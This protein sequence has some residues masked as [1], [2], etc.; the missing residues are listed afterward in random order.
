MIALGTMMNP[1][2]VMAK[3]M[4]RWRGI[5]LLNEASSMSYKAWVEHRRDMRFRWMPRVARWLYPKADGIVAP[6]ADI[7]RDLR[8]KIG[9]RSDMFALRIIPN[10]VDV[11]FIRKRAREEPARPD[12]IPDSEPLVIGV[13]RLARQ[14]NYPLLIRSFAKVRQRLPAR[15]L[16]LGE[17]PERKHLES[18]VAEL[19][20]DND[21]FLAG[22]VRNP[23][24]YMVRA[25]AFALSSEEEGFGLVL[26]EALACGCPIVATRCPGGPRE[27]LENGRVGILI[28]THDEDAM[29]NALLSLLEDDEKADRLRKLGLERSEQ[30]APYPI[31]L[32]WRRLIDEVQDLRRARGA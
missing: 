5:L 3:S 8:E 18:I 6:S 30:F 10:P 13:G 31:A 20:L 11:A 1:I 15:L 27:I 19:H 7:V 21:V 28:P 12:L 24:P 29:A 32:E 9:L 23:F 17:G 25:S 2:A 22:V 14:K 4:A 16:L 26:V